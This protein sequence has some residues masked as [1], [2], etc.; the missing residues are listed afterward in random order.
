MNQ[1][2]LTADGI[3]VSALGLK[4]KGKVA[5]VNMIDNPQLAGVLDMP[6]LNPKQLM[7]VLGSA[8]WFK[9]RIPKPSHHCRCKRHSKLPQIR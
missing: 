8:C 6:A 9:P 4:A 5:I 7:K 2:T 3:D 1:Q